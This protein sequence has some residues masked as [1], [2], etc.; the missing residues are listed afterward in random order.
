MHAAHPVD[1]VPNCIASH[2]DCL[3]SLF[4]PIQTHN[5]A[6]ARLGI[7]TAGIPARNPAL[8][9]AEIIPSTVF[10]CSVSAALS[11]SDE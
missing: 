3:L 6:H 11:V 8:H 9:T 7:P 4:N 5:P 2:R 10:L 1:C